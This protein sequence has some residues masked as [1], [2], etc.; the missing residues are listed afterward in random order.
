MKSGK[1]GFTL[2]E[3]VLVILLLSILSSVAIPKLG[4]FI[5]NARIVASKKEMRELARAIVGDPDEGLLGFQDD[6]G[7]LPANLSDLINRGTYDSFNPFT[8]T[9]WDGPYVGTKVD[10]D[11]NIDI[12]FDAWGNAYVYDAGAGTITSK[13]QDGLVGGTGPDADIVVNLN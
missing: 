11:G 7:A 9:G 3:L 6:N 12:L 1:N 4:D 2:I 13:G 5:Q 8:S 10:S